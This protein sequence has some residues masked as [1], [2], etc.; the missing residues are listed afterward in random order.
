MKAMPEGDIEI[1][2][3]NMAQTMSVAASMVVGLV[4]MFLKPED[5]EEEKAI[6]SWICLSVF[7]H[8][9]LSPS[10]HPDKAIGILKAIIAELETRHAND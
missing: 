9:L 2:P 4:N 5:S 10:K 6:H 8:Q 3:V 1:A 7:L